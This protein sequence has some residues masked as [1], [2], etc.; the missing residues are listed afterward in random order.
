[1]KITLETVLENEVSI[2][3]KA[4]VDVMVSSIPDLIRHRVSKGLDANDNPFA[5]Y[6]ASYRADL[7]AMGEN[8]NVDLRQTGG[9]MTSLRAQE[10]IYHGPDVAT[11]VVGLGTGTSPV[12]RPPASGRPRAARTGERGPAHSL[13]GMWHQTGAGSNP[14][15]R[16]AGLSPADRQRLNARLARAKA[17][18]Q[19]RVNRRT[20]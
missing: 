6:S 4:L 8:T 7:V 17:V 19:R 18:K 20:R 13:I 11:V 15:R 5:P 2:D 1:M 10:V 9:M 14:V 12:V 3:I 16:W